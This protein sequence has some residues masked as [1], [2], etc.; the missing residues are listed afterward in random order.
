MSRV[1]LGRKGLD[2]QQCNNIHA[3]ERAA[4]AQDLFLEEGIELAEL[5]SPIRAGHNSTLTQCLMHWVHEARVGKD[6]SKL[7]ERL[8]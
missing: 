2:A 3:E 7:G 8:V 4:G 1:Q 5:P 6:A